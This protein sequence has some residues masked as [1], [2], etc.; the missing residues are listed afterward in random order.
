MDLYA[1]AAKYDVKLLKQRAEKIVLCNIAESNALEIFGLAHLHNS[2]VLKRAA[3]CVIKQMFPHKEM[4][5]SLIVNPE[6][7]KII[8]ETARRIQQAQAEL[9]AMLDVE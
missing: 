4:N 5:E 1:L 2:A 6:K 9:D 3:F 7:L 8:V